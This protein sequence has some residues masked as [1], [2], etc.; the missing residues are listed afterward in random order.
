MET[1]KSND[2]M[3]KSTK[4]SHGKRDLTFNEHIY[5]FQK[6]TIRHLV[7]LLFL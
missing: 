4:T 5:F 7:V 2:R 1:D 3:G 6:S